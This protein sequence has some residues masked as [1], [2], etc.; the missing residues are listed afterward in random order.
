MTETIL[1]A[2][3]AALVLGLAVVFA[4]Q[5]KRG[6]AK[7]KSGYDAILNLGIVFLFVG[8]LQLILHGETSIFLMLGLVY[9][10]IGL[11]MKGKST[12][13]I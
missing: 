7:F 4:I 8:L 10:T 13:V 1:I 6:K 5:W 2:G 3:I 11:A 9:F 12:K